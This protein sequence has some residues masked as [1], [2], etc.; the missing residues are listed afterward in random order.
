MKHAFKNWLRL[1]IIAAGAGLPSPAS[2]QAPPPTCTS[3]NFCQPNVTLTDDVYWA[4]I[5]PACR[6]DA[7]MKA[8]GS[9]DAVPIAKAL[10]LQ[11]CLVDVPIQVWGLDPVLVMAT[12]QADD[13]QYVASGLMAF[14]PAP[15]QN[16]PGAIKVS[17]NAADYPSLAPVPVPVDTTSMVDKIVVRDKVTGDVISSTPNLLF[18]DDVGVGYY[19]PGPGAYNA[20]GLAVKSGDKFTQDGV[21]YTAKVVSGP[22]G[23]PTVHFTGPPLP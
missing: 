3:T 10:A 4:S 14:M 13:Y 11:G 20:K 19:A 5:P 12:R 6:P 18:V 7:L 21:V 23:I 16:L 17:V 2:A 9:A 22:L 15:G 1:L 8:R